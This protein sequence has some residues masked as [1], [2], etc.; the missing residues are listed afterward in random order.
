[1]G[2]FDYYSHK[3]VCVLIWLLTVL[4]TLRT[5]EIWEVQMRRAWQRLFSF[6]HKLCKA[7]QMFVTLSFWCC[8]VCVYKD[9]PCQQMS[10]C[11][12]LK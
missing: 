9:L 1:M 8:H 5:Y 11:M 2:V 12:K 7:E 10:V 6:L 4:H 3:N